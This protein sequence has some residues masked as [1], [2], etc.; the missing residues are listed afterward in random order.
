MR[1]A[2]IRSGLAFKTAVRAAG[3][4]ILLL[5]IAGSVLVV[6][7]TNTL[8]SE[9]HAQNEEQIVLLQQIYRTEGRDGLVQAVENLTRNPHGGEQT[10]GLFDKDGLR[11][12]GGLTSAPPMVGWQRTRIGLV[13]GVFSPGSFY[14]HRVLVDELTLVVGRSSDI[15]DAARWWL[16]FWLVLLGVTLTVC[17]LTLGYFAS[18]KSLQK[19]QAMEDVLQDVSQGNLEAR[20]AVAAENDQIDRISEQV[21]QHIARLSHLMERLQS[22]ATAIAHD[23]KTPL[24]D[25]QISLHQ[26]LDT[27]GA[28]KNPSDQIEAAQADLQRL[29]TIFETILRISNIEAG[30]GKPAFQNIDLPSL[31]DEIVE[32]LQPLAEESGQNIEIGLSLK[33]GAT[34]RGDDG[35]I[36]QLL[37]NI[38]SNAIAHCPAR[39]RIFLDTFEDRESITLIV[40]DNGPGIPATDRQRVLQPFVRLD[41][42]RTAPGSGL[43]LALVAAIADH[44][45]ATVQLDDA[46]PGL[47]LSIRFP[48][49]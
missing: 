20:L 2:D 8:E 31:V 46:G 35:M 9:L 39:T 19:L 13:E 41:S 15:V 32:F 1:R 30:R 34:L 22:T 42:A 6:A 3:I 23:L 44:H 45:N 47:R 14:L 36:K 26:A 18:R 16:T 37:V 48:K 4:F 17:T 43:G 25:A 28:N 24:S 38:I 11:L 12:A 49:L 21:N 10:A 27:I 29:N 5:L 7:V 33:S 40:E